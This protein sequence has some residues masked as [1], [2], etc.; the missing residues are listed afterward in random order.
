MRVRKRFGIIDGSGDDPIV[1]EE[2]PVRYCP[3]CLEFGF[4]RKLGPRKYILAAN[5]E[6]P[7]DH[8]SWLMCTEGCGNI[9]GKYE[10][11]NES[12]LKTNVKATDNPFDSGKSII[13]LKNVDTTSRAGTTDY[14][15]RKRR[16]KKEI[17]S[18]LKDSRLTDQDEDIKAEIRS[19]KDVKI[20]E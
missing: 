16:I 6:F 15:R 10:A 12:E 11:K 13:G 9:Y 2:E 20:L 18:K 5:E 17:D 3:H 1:E 8:E 19:G 7:I 4:K 14:Q